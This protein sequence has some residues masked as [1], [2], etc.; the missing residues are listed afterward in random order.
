MVSYRKG[1]N[2]NNIAESRDLGI[3]SCT[4]VSKIISLGKYLRLDVN[5][6][7]SQGRIQLL[8][9]VFGSRNGVWE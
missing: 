2:G 3:I 5:R 1:E 4:N 7:I 6:R 9:K 8:P